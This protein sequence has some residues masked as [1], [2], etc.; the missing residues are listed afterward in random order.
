VHE[1][2][3]CLKLLGFAGCDKVPRQHYMGEVD[4]LV[5]TPDQPNTTAFLSLLTAMHETNK[6]MICRFLPRSNG[7]PHLVVLTPRTFILHS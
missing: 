3:K 5:S 1:E 2:E 7:V 4:M 6:I